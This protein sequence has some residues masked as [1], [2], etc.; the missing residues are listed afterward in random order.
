MGNRTEL[1]M[2]EEELYEINEIDEQGNK[3]LLFEMANEQYGIAISRVTEIIEMQEITCVPD[4]PTFVKGVI[5]LRGRVIPLVDLR[6]RFDLE[7]KEYDDRTCTII[8]DIDGVE[9]GLIVDTVAEVQ[10]IR[11]EE[12]DPPPAFD[13][14]S[15]RDT[16]IS[17]LAR[18]ESDVAIM[19]NADQLIG[20]QELK[21]MADAV[22]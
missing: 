1:A 16:F 9:M 19:L 20:D 10:D 5:N 11:S 15:G 13:T 4:M 6:L 17:G 3:Y 18:L 12:I 2:S 21:V 22:E 7:E 14:A 8:I